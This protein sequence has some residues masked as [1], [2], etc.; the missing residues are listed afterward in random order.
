M[1]EHEV[2]TPDG[3]TLL[4]LERGDPTGVPLLVHNGTPNSR[5]LLD[6]HVARAQQRGGE[7]QKT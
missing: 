7:D 3:R 6:E 1:T 2:A 5:L 4:V